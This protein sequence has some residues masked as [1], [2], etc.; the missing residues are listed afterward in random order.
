MPETLRLTGSETVTIRE[1]S[2]GLLEVEGDWQGGGKPPPAHYHPDQDEHFEV[3]EGKIH[4]V[5]DGEERWYETGETFDIPAGVSH[6][7][8]AEGPTRMHW[9]VRPALRTAEFFERFYHALD[10]GFPDGTTA[11][12]FLAEYSD[13]FRLTPAE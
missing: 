9:E 12:E 2:P 10:N 5:I 8:A 13:V 7:M 4:A 11:E 1:S 6:Q 3:L